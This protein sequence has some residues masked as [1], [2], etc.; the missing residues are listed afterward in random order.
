L[1]IARLILTSLALNRHSTKGKGNLELP[2]TKI[3]CA[4]V[5]HWPLNSKSIQCGNE[6]DGTVVAEY[7]QEMSK[8]IGEGGIHFQEIIPTIVHQMK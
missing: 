6:F 2:R 4:C 8:Q 3:S 5:E 7:L 1:G